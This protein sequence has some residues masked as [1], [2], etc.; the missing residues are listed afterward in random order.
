M[1]DLATLTIGDDFDNSATLYAQGAAYNVSTATAIKATITNADGTVKYCSD[2][3]LD[4][5][6]AGADWANGVIVYNFTAAITAEIADYVRA[7]E[8]AR[9]ETQVEINGSKYTWA[10]PINIQMGNIA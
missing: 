3:T 2:V 10:A 4:S 9:L 1:T 5:G 7:P 6:A 8:I